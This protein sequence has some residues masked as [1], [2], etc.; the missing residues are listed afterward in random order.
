[1]TEKVH[2]YRSYRVS[3][4]S[5]VPLFYKYVSWDGEAIDHNHWVVPGEEAT[6]DLFDWTVSD[7][8]PQIGDPVNWV[9]AFMPPPHDEYV[10][11]WDEGT[12]KGLYCFNNLEK[13]VEY[14]THLGAQDWPVVYAKVQLAGVIV[15]HE[16]GY[17][18]QMTRISELYSH[19]SEAGRVR[20]A[21]EVG[22]PF[23]IQ[24]LP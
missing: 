20:L 5:L 12:C 8:E 22:W 23:E 1:M 14:I 21:N 3:N 4:G 10:N 2:G 24:E 19:Q 6:V 15:E 18:A 17:R 9:R 16:N 13:A 7:E 11:L